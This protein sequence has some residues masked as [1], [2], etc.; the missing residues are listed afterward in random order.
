[1][2]AGVFKHLEGG[3]IPAFETEDI[4]GS[5]KSGVPGNPEM[6]TFQAIRRPGGG[7]PFIIGHYR[8]YTGQRG[9]GASGVK[10]FGTKKGAGIFKHG[11]DGRTRTGDLNF[12]P[13]VRE[14]P[15]PSVVILNSEFLAVRRLALPYAAPF[16]YSL[17]A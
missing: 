1:M 11:P 4:T 3:Q 17:S 14:G 12:K 13:K 16:V 9:G 6:S 7:P 8:F 2:D 5:G 15:C 10:H